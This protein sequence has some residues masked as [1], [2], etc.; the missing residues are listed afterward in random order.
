MGS[1]GNDKGIE[2]SVTVSADTPRS[3]TA[4]D[5]SIR[6]LR[7]VEAIEG[8]GPEAEFPKLKLRLRNLAPKITNTSTDEIPDAAIT[9][10]AGD[11]QTGCMPSRV[12]DEPSGQ[13]ESSLHW[14][15][16]TPTTEASTPPSQPAVKPGS[17]SNPID[18]DTLK[19]PSP[20]KFLLD[21]P[22]GYFAPLPLGYR[23]SRPKLAPKLYTP[24]G[25]VIDPSMIRGHQ[26]HDIYQILATRKVPTPHGLTFTRPQ[27]GPAVTPPKAL[28][29]ASR[30]QGPHSNGPANIPPQHQPYPTILPHHPSRPHNPYP[31]FYQTPAN[32][33]SIFPIQDETL[34]RKRAV[35]YILNH[36]RPRPRKRRLSDDPDETSSSEYESTPS[37][38]NTK[39]ARKTTRTP[40]KIPPPDFPATNTPSTG[41][42]EENMF[43]RNLKLTEMVEHMQLVTSLLMM[44]PYS[45]DQKGLREDISML[46]TVTDKRLQAW[47]SAE[48][49]LEVETR[50]RRRTTVTTPTPSPCNAPVMHGMN[51]PSW[52]GRAQ[53]RVVVLMEDTIRKQQEEREKRTK[54][55][56][57]RRYLSGE[58]NV[59]GKSEEQ[60]DAGGE[61]AGPPV[62]SGVAP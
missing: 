43:D 25:A 9:D 5:E 42:S 47:L 20:H 12:M 41:A 19:T 37:D 30:F 36:S 24:N 23:P 62:D 27:I 58:S 60:V 50:E 21:R 8:H 26:S 56:E 45:G 2:T 51:I 17:A 49:E 16:T 59:W 44:Y 48:A 61:V 15:H 57:L 31:T 11:H 34:L 10:P 14:T 3:A 33:Y 38:A 18:V 35:Q 22:I 39:R 54:E 46:A 29:A 32:G 28:A 55:T 52:H 1:L 13:H 6:P 40:T 7:P 4:K 53:T